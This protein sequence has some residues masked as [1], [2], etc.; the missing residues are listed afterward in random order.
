M[1]ERIAVSVLW[2]SYLEEAENQWTKSPKV[3]MHG[4]RPLLMQVHI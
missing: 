3:L 1:K 4:T 2:L